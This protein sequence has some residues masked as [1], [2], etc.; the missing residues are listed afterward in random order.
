MDGH[1]MAFWGES[2]RYKWTAAR[3]KQF[4][5]LS[6]SRLP[7]SWLFSR[8]YESKTAFTRCRHILK[9]MKKVTV[10]KFELAFTR[11]RQNLKTVGNLSVKSWLQDFD[12]IERYLQPK[13]QWVFFQKRR[14]L[15][16]FKIFKCL[17][18]AVSKMCRLEFRFQNLPFSKSAGKKMCRFRV[19]RR[20][21]RRIFHRF[22]NVPTSCERSLS[23][24]FKSRVNVFRF[25]T[26]ES[27]PWQNYGT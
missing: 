5:L 14:K 24:M 16:Y 15:F 3:C 9:T 10:A 12:A 17:H 6:F 8:M 21:I 19:N 1:G 26:L 13:C 27:S 2:G 23:L 4:C 18:D 11:C 22:Q 7:N 25:F 20:P